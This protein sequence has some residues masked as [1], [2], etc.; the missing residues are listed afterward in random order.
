MAKRKPFSSKLVKKDN[1][2]LLTRDFNDFIR[3]ALL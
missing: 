1:E 3:S 2:D